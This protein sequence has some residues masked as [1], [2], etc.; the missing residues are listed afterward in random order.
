ML[1]IIF[2][3][4]W[5]VPQFYLVFLRNSLPPVVELEKQ[6]KGRKKE[7]GGGENK[8]QLDSCVVTRVS[9]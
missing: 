3:M 8:N 4:P 2:V 6:L 9:S 7:G 1:F 5:L